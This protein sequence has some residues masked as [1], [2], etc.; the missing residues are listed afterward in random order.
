[1]AATGEWDAIPGRCKTHRKE[2]DFKNKWPPNDSPLHQIMRTESC[3]ACS[4]EIQQNIYDMK[5]CAVKALLE[6][7]PSQASAT[8]VFQRTPLHWACM[9]LQGNYWNNPNHLNRHGGGNGNGDRDGDGDGAS[10]RE[11]DSILLDLMDRAP[12]AVSLVDLEKRTPLH[13][14]L[15]RSDT[16]IP[17]SMLAKLVALCPQ[18][19]DMKDEVGETPLDILETRKDEIPNATAVKDTLQKLKTMLTSS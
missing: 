7:N 13:Y 10:V 2:A 18:A 15:A 6:A 1:M 5:Q 19:L 9:D 4:E 3:P 16:E 12:Q 17:L 11:D 14:L 8:D